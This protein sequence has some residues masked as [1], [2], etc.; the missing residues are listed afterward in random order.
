MKIV[1]DSCTVRYKIKE[2]CYNYFKNKYI[3]SFQT[4][5]LSLKDLRIFSLN[6]GKILF[7]REISS[8]DDNFLHLDFKEYV[9]ITY[10]KELK[11]RLKKACFLTSQLII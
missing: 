5:E 6:G 3:L 2:D 10:D 11:R 1:L 8:G 7:K 9:V 4:K